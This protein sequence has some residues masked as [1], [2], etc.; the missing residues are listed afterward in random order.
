MSE[1][2]ILNEASLPFF[3]VDDCEENLAVFFE[4]LHSANLKGITFYRADGLEGD[5]IRWFMRKG[6]SLENGSV[7]LKIMTN[8]DW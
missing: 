1:S 6:L 7:K 4:I 5:G 2:L 3:S 8:A